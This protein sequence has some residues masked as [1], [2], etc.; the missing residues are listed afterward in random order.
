[1][2][3][4]LTKE[5]VTLFP[6]FVYNAIMTPDGT[7][8][9]SKHR[10][11]YILYEDANGEKY[12]LDGGNDYRRTHI[13]EQEATDISVTYSDSIDKIREHL[14]WGTYGIE[15]SLQLKEVLL[16]D[17]SNDHIKAIINDGYKLNPVM[18]L[19]LL[20]RAENGIIILD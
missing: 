12:M 7:I 8:L 11:D 6:Q 19:E 15:G 13:N 4:K 5:E 20:Y 14:V 17:M 16:K 10:H 2:S 18:K 1:M 9:H 3:K